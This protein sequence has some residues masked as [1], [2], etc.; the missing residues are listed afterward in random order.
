MDA[1]ITRFICYFSICEVFISNSFYNTNLEI[2]FSKTTYDELVLLIII[3]YLEIYKKYNLLLQI[4]RCLPLFFIY[5]NI[6][7][8]L[9]LL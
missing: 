6:C 1:R 3:D 7:N 9:L 8:Y 4:I 5:K 2:N